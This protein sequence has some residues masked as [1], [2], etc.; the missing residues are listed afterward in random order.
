M[1]KIKEKINEIV[2]KVKNDKDFAA[3]F[4]KDPIKAVES[5]IGVDLPDDQIMKIVDGVKA[6]IQVDNA[7]DAVNKLKG[8]FK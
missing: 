3:K 1:E 5:V 4:K 8:L 6:K 7:G 2:D